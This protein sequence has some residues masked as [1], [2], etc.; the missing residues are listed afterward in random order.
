MPAGDHVVISLHSYGGTVETTEGAGY[1]LVGKIKT[2][3]G[4]GD[5]GCLM[6]Y[7]NSSASGVKTATATYDA[8]SGWAALIFTLPLT[9]GVAPPAPVSSVIVGG[10]KK[11]VTSRSVIIGG[12]KKTV[13]SRSVIVGGVKK[14]TV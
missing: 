11:A 7:A 12:V 5:R 9:A 4:T 2:L 3:S 14:A 1:T 13:T 10:V 6:Q 8:T